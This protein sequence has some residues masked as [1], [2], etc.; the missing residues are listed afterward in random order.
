M[1]ID[2]EDVKTMLNVCALIAALLG[3]GAGAI[4]LWSAYQG[5][6]ED[7]R[8]AKNGDL[9]LLRLN[10]GAMGDAMPRRMRAGLTSASRPSGVAS[11][12]LFSRRCQ[13]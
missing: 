9:V 8:K 12:L 5:A 10:R 11:E 4:P 3:V 7:R 2:I 13:H 6:R 1:D